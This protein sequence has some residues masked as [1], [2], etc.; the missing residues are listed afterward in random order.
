VIANVTANKV[1]HTVKEDMEE[2]LRYLGKTGQSLGGMTGQSLA[3]QISQ[4]WQNQN[5]YI[6]TITTA[7][8]LPTQSFQANTLTKR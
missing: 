3:G 7:Q 8:T 6:P 1:K 5:I 4:D 2:N